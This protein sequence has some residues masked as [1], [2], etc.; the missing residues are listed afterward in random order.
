MKSPA[1]E[2]ALLEK[3]VEAFHRQTGKTIEL[4]K[5]VFSTETRLDTIAKL[6]GESFQVIVKASVTNQNL[7]AVLNELSREASYA[8]I[9]LVTRYINPNLMD[10]LREANLSCIDTAGNAHIHT[11]QSYIFI[12]GNK[13]LQ[14]VSFLKKGRSFQ[15][16]GLKVIFALLQNPDLIT[17]TYRDIAEQ[18]NVALGSVGLILKD[19]VEQGFIQKKGNNRSF[20]EK[21]R[22]LNSWV[23]HYPTLKKKHYLGTFTTDTRGWWR[24]ID[25][26]QYGAIW[27][28]EIAA[29]YLSNYLQAKDGVVFISQSMMGDFLKNARLRKSKTEEE[30]RVELIE[31]FWGVGLMQ[32]K[33]DL[34]P[35]LLVYADLINSK[36]S[37]NLET[38]QRIY[39]QY[40]N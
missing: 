29:E 38:A 1:N 40:F 19:L 30:L 22:L 2:V 16:A 10:K 15:Y 32:E 5:Q 35:V 36:D 3:A 25:I 17:G 34:A 11:L 37:R 23:E 6:E 39:E 14:E 26:Q 27:A 4:S 9:L 7:H 21:E 12:K 31:P 20:V 8:P 13:L 33:E 18:A 24:N 28:G